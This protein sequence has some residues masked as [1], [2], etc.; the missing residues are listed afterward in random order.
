MTLMHEHILLDTSSWW[1]RP[2][3]ASDIGFAER[4][5]D[6][7]MIGD[8]RMNPF[9]NRDNCG[10]LDVK[11]AIEELD[12]FCRIRRQDRRRSDQP[13]HR[14]RPV[15]AAADQ[16]AHGTQHRDGRGLLSRA[17][18]SAL[19]QG[20]VGRSD[21]RGHRARLRRLGGR[22]GSLRRNHR[23]DRDQQGLHA[24][25]GEGAAGR[26]ARVQ[27]ERRSALDPSAGLG[28]SCPSGARRASRAK[29]PTCGMPCSAI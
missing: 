5:L 15:G 20:H 28:A 8:L 9:L 3:C 27:D 23:R 26:R 12:A 16:P 11:A 18:A 22:A 21:R 13:R 29:A 2:C 19:R 6:I 10:L 14:P 7:S 24:G 1:K 4:P 25:R 17:V